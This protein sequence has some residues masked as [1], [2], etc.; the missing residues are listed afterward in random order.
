MKFAHPIHVFALTFFALL[1][2][3]VE[4]CTDRD[5]TDNYTLIVEAPGEA[6]LA[7]NYQF[8]ITFDGELVDDCTVLIGDES[9]ECGANRCIL[10]NSCDLVDA[11]DVEVKRLQINTAFWDGLLPTEVGLNLSRDGSPVAERTFTPDY[12]QT[13]P[14]LE[15]CDQTVCISAEDTLVLPE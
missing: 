2:G 5:C 1:Q 11:L 10:Q 9:S 8:S 12:I 6:M 3:C 13:E 15:A 7:G 4:V 14:D